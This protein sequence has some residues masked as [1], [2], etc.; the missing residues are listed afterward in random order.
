MHLRRNNWNNLAIPNE[1]KVDKK[2]FLNTFFM[3]LVY[4]THFIMLV[5]K[6]LSRLSSCPILAVKYAFLQSTIYET[7]SLGHFSLNRGTQN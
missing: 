5:K 7:K 3:S 6:F 1:G 4:L 2:I